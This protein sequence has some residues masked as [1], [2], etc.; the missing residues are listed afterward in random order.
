MTSNAS[1]TLPVPG[2]AIPLPSPAAAETTGL[3]VQPPLAILRAQLVMAA[4]S[5]GS[6]IASAILTGIVPPVL[7]G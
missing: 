4:L 7:E 1:P 6:P 5:F 3:G 2:P